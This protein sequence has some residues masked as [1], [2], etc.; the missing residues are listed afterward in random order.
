MIHPLQK[1]D[2]GQVHFKI[3]TKKSLEVFKMCSFLPIACTYKPICVCKTQCTSLI[4]TVRVHVHIYIPLFN[5]S[6]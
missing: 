3:P 6:G 2:Y 1:F 5:V 4:C